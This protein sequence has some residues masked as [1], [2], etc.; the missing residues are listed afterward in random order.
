M[1]SLTTGPLRPS[2][3][4]ELARI[5]REAFP[6]FFLSSL[7]EPFL[8]QFY[9][10]FVGQR[11]SV[12]VENKIDP[13]SGAQSGFTRNYLAVSMIDAARFTNQEVSVRLDGMRNGW[14]TGAV[15]ESDFHSSVGDPSCAAS[16]A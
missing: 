10:G 11:A 2:D 13:S 16:S 8:R 6:T 5:H 15:S 9:A 7:G 1:T 4:A 12:L 3:V 14:L